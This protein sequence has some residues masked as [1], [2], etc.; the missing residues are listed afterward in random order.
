MTLS[1]SSALI[2]GTF[3]CFGLFLLGITLGRG[4]LAY[5]NLERTVTVKGLS[6]HEYPADTVIWPITYSVQN[7]ALEGLYDEI[8]RNNEKVMRFLLENGI[9]A[10]EISRSSPRV[11]DK[12]SQHYNPRP[13]Q[14]IRFQAAQ[15]LTVHSQNIE[16]VKAL[17]TRLSELGK[18]GVII[19]GENY[20][21]RTEYIFSALNDIKPKMIE[22][23]TQNA[24]LVAEKFSED[25][26]S[27]LGKIK[28]ARQGQFSIT[29]RDQNNPDI[30]KIRVVS[31]ITYYLSD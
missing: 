27:Q 14:G 4:A 24:R 10:D 5:K 12:L 13:F 23:A 15:T 28:T 7:N 8:D 29:A 25:S 1:K 19:T 17:M 22:E 20:E 3:I 26:Q 18:Q 16:T 30:K 11:R 2:L 9:K 6:V 31:T 21:V